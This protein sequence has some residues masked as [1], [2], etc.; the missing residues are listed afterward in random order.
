M[1]HTTKAVGV[2]L[3]VAF[4]L[5]DTTSAQPPR[6]PRRAAVKPPSF[7]AAKAA[8]E[9]TAGKPYVDRYKALQVFAQIKTRACVEYLV[10]V[11]K[12]SADASIKS[13]ALRIIGQVGVDPARAEIEAVLANGS[14]AEKSTA[15]SALGAVRPK[16]PA[17][18]FLQA[19]SS[20]NLSLQTSAANALGDYPEPRVAEALTTVLSTPKV[21]RS[22][23]RTCDR[24]LKRLLANEAVVRWLV[25][26]A[27]KSA[28]TEP[29]LPQ[30]LGLAAGIPRK[31]RP[32]ST[33]KAVAVHLEHRSPRVRSAAADALGRLEKNRGAAASESLDRLLPLLKDP[34]PSVVLAGALAV[35]QIGPSGATLAAVLKLCKSKSSAHRAVGISVLARAQTPEARK[36]AL[37]ALGDKAF[38][39]RAAAVATLEVQGGKASVDA[40]IK[41]LKKNRSGRLQHDILRALR[42]LTGASPG[43][44]YKHWK[45]WWA[46]VR[47]DYDLAKV[48]GPGQPKTRGGSSAR[49][50]PTYYGSEIVSRRLTFVI[51][52]S[53][54]M[55]AQVP[56]KEGLSQTRLQACQA[57]LAG[58]IRSLPK[59]ARFNIIAFDHNFAKWQKRL[60]PAGRAK[61]VALKYVATLKPSG[62]TNIFDPLESALL[63][64]EVDTVYLLSDGSPGSGKFTAV[65]DI[66]R[67][68]KKINVVRQCVIHTISIGSKSKLLEK[69][70]KQNKGQ[71]LVR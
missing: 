63:D 56:G 57:E 64:P 26:T 8:F 68:V 23:R 58:V 66:L 59:A 42:T 7:E 5:A 35:G 1:R 37:K 41:A 9:K 39:V 55:S 30:L 15:L 40:L 25:E 22:I 48:R 12:A 53:G 61:A 45:A 36:A 10:R 70:A 17:D 28:P 44:A 29:A 51:D 49:K 27:L 6:R 31:L 20:S 60:M 2:A 19:L 38:P 62:G 32:A 14:D 11:R 13:Q 4:G 24:S 69:L 67:E 71:A 50:V 21:N 33:T 47:D 65:E 34:D 16:V 3:L 46:K 43:A 54:S 52:I 18:P